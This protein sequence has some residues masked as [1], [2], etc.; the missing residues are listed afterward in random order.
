VLLALALIPAS[1]L[2]T[3]C[4]RH[5]G[6]PRQPVVGTL[7]FNGTPVPDA[8]VAFQCPERHIYFTAITDQQGQL[9]VRAASGDGLPAGTYQVTVHP[10]PSDDEEATQVPLRPD[11][12]Q[13]YRATSTSDL[14]V[15]VDEGANAFVVAMTGP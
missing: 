3:G 5:S 15:T 13:K 11:I 4:G 9:E 6:P 10:A 2:L 8:Q 1:T 14:T 7:T 12:P